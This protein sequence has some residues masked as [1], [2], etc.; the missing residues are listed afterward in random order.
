MPRLTGVLAATAVAV[1]SMVTGCSDNEPSPSTAATSF[2]H[3]HGLGINPA[4]NRLYVA[5]HLGVFKQ[6]DSGFERVADRQQDTMAFTVTGTDTFLAGGHP[7]LRETDKPIHLRLIEST[8]AAQTWDAL[9]LAGEADFHALEPAGDRVY[10]YDSNNGVLKVTSDKRQWSDIARMGVI[11]LAVNPGNPD[12]LLVTDNRTRLQ[13]LGGGSTLRPVPGAP[14]LAFVDWPA[15]DLLVGVG[16]DGT[17]RHSRDGGKTWTTLTSVGSAP[18]AF[19]VTPNIWH[20]ATERGVLA[21]KDQGRT[22]SPVAGQ[23]DNRE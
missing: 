8:D 1:A 3:V 2:G 23:L 22:W 18:E 15:P 17:V 20:V 6:T 16:P 5:S 7:D 14:P 10:G 11:D 4:D 12:G 13:R 21:S 9:S 19:D